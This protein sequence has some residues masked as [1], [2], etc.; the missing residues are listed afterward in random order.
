[1][2]QLLAMA[3]VCTALGCAGQ[4]SVH[5]CSPL[6]ATPAPATCSSPPA[7][8]PGCLNGQNSNVGTRQQHAHSKRKYDD[9]ATLTTE[10]E[11]DVRRDWWSRKFAKA[12]CTPLYNVGPVALFD[13][14][15]HNLSSKDMSFLRAK[16]KWLLQQPG[17]L[18]RVELHG[19]TDIAGSEDFNQNLGQR[20][21]IAV[22]TYLSGLNIDNNLIVA[23]SRGE[24]RPLDQK[25]KKRGTHNRR[26]EMWIRWRC[27]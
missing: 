2:R 26:V 16:T 25:T 6:S 24:R 17:E 3:L 21:A 15:R 11:D 12:S 14:E 18:M 8:P 7:Q 5:S 19:H 4:N 27:P 22:K 20:R 13:F 10:C 23:I 9:D 1:M